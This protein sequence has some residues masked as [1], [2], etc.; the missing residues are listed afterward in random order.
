[1]MK[2]ILPLLLV[3]ALGLFVNVVLQAT[4]ARLAS[5]PAHLRFQFASFAGG[6][7]LTV[8][9]LLVLLSGLPASVADKLGYLAMHALI[10]V[11]FGF[12]FFNVISANVSSLRVRVLKELLASLP[13]PITDAA[14][15]ARYSSREM[16]LARLARLEQGGQIECRTGRFYICG[17]GVSLIGK[18]FAGMRRLLLKA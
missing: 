17:S 2:G 18:F 16:L 13:R 5:K 8:I 11:C 6:A 15:R 9:L 10:Y 12:C 4:M 7:L 1:M 3:P 14:L